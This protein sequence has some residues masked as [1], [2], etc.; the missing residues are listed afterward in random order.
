MKHKKLFLFSLSAYI[1][2]TNIAISQVGINTTEPKS[3]FDVTA[4][5]A[6]NKVAGMQAPRLTLAQLTNKGNTLYSA[7]QTG[8]IIYITDISGGDKTGQRENIALPGYYY[9]DGTLW[10]KLGVQGNSSTQA[11]EVKDSFRSTD[12]DGWYLLNG[13][14]VSSLPTNVRSIANSLGF[15]TSLPDAR[16]RVLKTKTGTEAL[17]STGGSNTLTLS[18]ANLPNISLSASF[19]GTAA[20][21]GA[22]T[23]PLNITSGSTTHAHTFSTA[24]SENGH[25]HTFGLTSSNTTHTHSFNTTSSSAGAHTHPYRQAARQNTNHSGGYSAWFNMNQQATKTSGSAGAHSHNFS[26]NS[27]SGG[28]AHTHTFSATVGSGGAAHTHTFNG[29]SASGGAAHTHT[30]NGTSASGGAAHAHS[31]S[32]TTSIPL[33]GSSAALNNRSAYLVTNTFVY[34]GI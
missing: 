1:L 16:D 19:N 27:A 6:T 11:G 14:T 29:T 34:L 25:N 10:Q 4:S 26:G 12:H 22:H 13:R 5:T 30:F 15:T 3:T 33:G 31:V 28:A 20:S 2:S 23:H 21:A 9:F 24:S 32:G 7:D 8:T 17:G 18:Q